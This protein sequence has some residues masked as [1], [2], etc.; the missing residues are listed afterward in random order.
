LSDCLKENIKKYADKKSL[1]EI[2][3]EVNYKQ[4]KKDLI[5]FWFAGK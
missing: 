5:D 2:F 1:E 3:T 4:D